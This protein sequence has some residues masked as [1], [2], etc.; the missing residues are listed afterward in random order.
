MST[1]EPT[2]P[3]HRDA[4]TRAGGDGAA[5]AT[6]TAPMYGPVPAA[7]ER[8][9]AGFVEGIFLAPVA[10]GRPAPV[11]EVEALA[12]HGLAGDRYGAGI[13]SYSGREPSTGRA[14]TL[15]AAEALEGLARDTGIA[16]APGVHRRNVV[17]RGVDLDALLGKRF[18]VG[19]VECFGARP[20]TPCAHLESLT[21]PGV[22]KGLVNRGGLRV[23]VL[24]NGRIA[25]GDAIVVL[26]DGA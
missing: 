22:L 21:Q 25:V 23:D 12:G 8:G 2:T 10:E 13:G 18:R 19:T 26:G 24:T 9:S 4:A 15:I 16:L 14:L 11:A 6:P 7:E 5:S 17:T 20:C 3:A 1:A